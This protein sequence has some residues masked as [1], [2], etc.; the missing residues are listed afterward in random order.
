MFVKYIKQI[1]KMF[2]FE[3]IEIHLTKVVDAQL[4]WLR[5]VVI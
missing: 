3:S 2:N 5:V 1:Y 4:V